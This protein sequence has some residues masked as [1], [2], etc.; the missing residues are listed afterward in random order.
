MNFKTKSSLALSAAALLFL[1]ACGDDSSKTAAP[2]EPAV[3]PTDST[4]IPTPLPTDS[5]TVPTDSAANPTD[6]SAATNPTVDPSTL[7]AEG[8]ITLPE[9]KGLLVD[10]F[11]DGDN[12]SATIDNYWYTYSD[13]D[14]D[15]A[16]VITTPVNEDGDIIA[17]AVNN[18]S[19][20]ALQVN[21]TLDKGEYAYD[22]YV[23]WGIQ[24][25]EDD[26]NGRFG[27]ITY[28]YKGGAHEVHIEISDVTDYDVH[29]AKV[30]ASRTWTQAVIR[31]KDLVQGGWGTEVPFDAKHIRAISFQAKGNAKVTSDS[32]F[33]DNIYLQDTSEVEAD[34]PDMTIND[35]VIPTVE[36]TE[37]EITVTSPLQAKA[38]KYLNKGINFTNWL[39]NADGKFKEF[40]FDETDIKLL[41]DNGI[42][43]LRLPIDLD[44]YAT[45]RD[46][47]VKDTTGTVALDFDDSTLFTV[48]DS[49]VEWT[50][51]HNMSFVIDYH[52]YDNSYNAT[53]AKD[54]KYIQM[55][56]ETWKHVATHYAE[57][58]REDIF[59]EL[60][61]EPDMS[62]GKVTAAQWTVAAQ[63]M[64]DSI[65]SVDKKH[66][67]LFGDAQ[68]YSISLLAKRTPFTDDNIVYVI[69]TYEPFA[70]THQ[71]GSWTDYATIKG[72]PFPY[73]P[74]KWSTVSGDF[75]VTKSTQSYVKSN[76]KNYYK[77]G[78]KEAIM[79]QILKAKK[80]AAT[81]NVPVI[82]N[83]FGA[84]NL[85]STAQD[86]LNYLTAMREICDTLQIPWTHW[87]YTGN[88]SLFEGDLKGTKLIDGIDKALGLGAAE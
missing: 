52:E 33:I 75:G 58:T 6:S 27:G 22:P 70:F 28:W 87:G 48:L 14:N 53:S 15:G 4:T 66:T 54:N 11:E 30:K 31:F 21:Y 64:I 9:G 2:D 80:W 32:L 88:F 39:E 42:K 26:A 8:P 85:R 79:E 63:A 25:A 72:I 47:F 24:V 77:T 40:V 49:F 38:M 35:P 55:M 17:G 74:A 1:S 7:P 18:G 37:A 56:A 45:N 68:W 29:L 65:R 20:Y 83:E 10:D 41:A 69:H 5:T 19:K 61:N 71:G 51:N 50:G 82:I 62:A 76:I 23:G 13:N 86:R 84:L 44:L 67:I 59:F 60:L 46:A 36:F 57:N 34:K 12:H 73:N 78:S 43:S 81:N 3:N 16:S